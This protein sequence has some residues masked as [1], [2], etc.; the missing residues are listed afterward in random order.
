M[1][2]HVKRGK[3]DSARWPVGTH[4]VFSNSCQ[5]NPYLFGPY[6]PPEDTM[7]LKFI[8]VLSGSYTITQNLKIC[9]VFC[10]EPG[11]CQEFAELKK[12]T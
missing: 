5:P 11:Q 10:L 9:V 7:T 8:A 6:R 3:G 1:V 2:E 4:H 12:K